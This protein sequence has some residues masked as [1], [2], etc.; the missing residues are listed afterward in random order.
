MSNW[1]Q[2]KLPCPV[3]PS[4]DAYHVHADGHGYCF[5]CSYYK[6]SKD[7]FVDTEYTYEYLPYR[8]L[9]K[10]TLRTYDMKTKIDK[11][12]KPISVGYIM[13]NGDIKVRNL[14]T[15]EFYWTKG[16]NQKSCGL[17][18]MD[19]FEPGKFKYITI[20]E[21][22]EDAASLHQVL[23]GAP[24]VSVHSASS[25]YND[26]V[27]DRN[28]LNAYERI[29]LA[30]DADGPGR[31]ATEKLAKLFDPSKIYVVKFGKR[32]DANEYLLNGEDEELKKIWWNSKLYLP[33]KIVNQ[34]SDIEPLLSVKPKYGIPAYP[35]AELNKYLYGI[36]TG[37][38]VL[39]I[40]QEKIGKTE[41]MHDIE[42]S[43]LQQTDWNI[44]AIYLEEPAQRHAQA[45]AGLHLELPVHRPDC[46]VE[47]AQI[48]S[49]FKE[50]VREDGRLFIYSHFG[51][52]DPDVF[53]DLIRFL[54]T[55][56]GVRCVLFDHLTMVVSG[57]QGDDERRVLDY[58]STRLEMMVK[59][60]D[61]SLIMVSHVNDEGKTR[62]SRNLTKVADVT[63]A[64]ERDLQSYD[65]VERRTVSFNIRYNRP[66]SDTGPAGKCIY[67]PEKGILEEVKGGEQEELPYIQEDANNKSTLVPDRYGAG[68]VEADTF[69][70][71]H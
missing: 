52:D 23:Q 6:P 60:L 63:I 67:I 53:L 54:V 64:L 22:Y 65:P 32:K 71:T 10:E 12:G 13:P 61:F 15:K 27:V 3:C 56:R 38:T 4:S 28:K 11:D 35:T 1:V 57:H 49:A 8:K 55:A 41:V 2:T 29:Y 51:S 16:S 33:E 66:Y 25:A 9:T 14:D 24:V 42:Y 44:A 43:L 59:E 62:G 70:Q 58:L 31:E 30:L 47:P 68:R 40:A 36:R 7:N 26:C 34:F 37:E 20:T 48:F 18:G 39:F 17:F 19:K 46:N 50:A 69:L 21:G 5:S 45:I